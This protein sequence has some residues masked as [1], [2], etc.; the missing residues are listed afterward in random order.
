MVRSVDP[1][2]K[3]HELKPAKVPTVLVFAVGTAVWFAVLVVFVVRAILG[4]GLDGYVV[5][6]A[7]V[8]IAIGIGGVIWGRV[9]T[10][11]QLARD[12]ARQP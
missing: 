9:H 3:P 1:E 6:T 12:A 11:R 4:H 2:A 10:R 7:A 5:A 8:G